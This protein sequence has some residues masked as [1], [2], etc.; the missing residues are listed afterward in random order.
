MNRGTSEEEDSG[1]KDH[2]D[3]FHSSILAFFLINF[4]S[5]KGNPLIS[6]HLVRKTKRGEG[7][8]EEEEEG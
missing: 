3:R 7:D 2:Q 6:F 4:H 8:L 1:K 5:Y